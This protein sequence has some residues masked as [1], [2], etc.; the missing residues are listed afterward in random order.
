[1]C[2]RFDPQTLLLWEGPGICKRWGPVDGSDLTGVR[3]LLALL[4][5]PPWEP[6][7]SVQGGWCSAWPPTLTASSSQRWTEPV[8]QNRPFLFVNSLSQGLWSATESWLTRFF[9]YENENLR[10][11]N[12]CPLPLFFSR[13]AS[14]LA[15]EHTSFF[16]R[17]RGFQLSCVLL[18]H[19]WSDS[20]GG[21]S[22]WT[23]QHVKEIAPGMDIPV[24]D[25]I[26]GSLGFVLAS[27]LASILGA[28]VTLIS[29]FFLNS[30]ASQG[31]EKT[32]WAVLGFIHFP[33]CCG[34]LGKKFP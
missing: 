5:H 13:S 11:K 17:G 14:S 10:Y 27:L 16:L 3:A 7:P 15:P 33:H 8:S 34:T 30:S 32:L 28:N 6:F 20:P 25:R 9:P 18:S 29:C 31:L 24:S 23:S 4:L 19:G 26:S 22:R 2:G 21:R 1:M 12:V